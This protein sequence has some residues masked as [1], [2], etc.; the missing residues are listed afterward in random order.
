MISETKKM[1]EK[2]TYHIYVNG[3]PVYVD[4]EEDEFDKQLLYLKNFLQ[5]TNLDKNA[6]IE[7]EVLRPPRGLEASY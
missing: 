3:S 7:Y 5:L 1:P 6:R 2:T 4:L